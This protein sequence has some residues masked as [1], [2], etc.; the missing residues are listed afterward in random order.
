MRL[1]PQSLPKLVDEFVKERL[2]TFRSVRAVYLHGSA[3][4]G[5]ALT[6]W[7]SG[8]IDLVFIHENTPAVTGELI[9]MDDNFHFDIQHTSQE[10][11]KNPRALRTHSWLGPAIYGFKILHDPRHLLDFTQAS[12]RDRFHSPGYV[13]ARA[14]HFLN[15][16][17]AHAEETA[18]SRSLQMSGFLAGIADALNGFISLHGPPSGARRLFRD[19]YSHAQL[20]GHPE[21]YAL[22]VS[23]LGAGSINRAELASWL[24]QWET[25]FCAPAQPHRGDA[26]IHPLRFRYFQHALQDMLNSERP[27]DGLWLLLNTWNKSIAA[28]DDH[29]PHT[30]WEKV[31]NQLDFAQ[32]FKGLPGL[33]D[34]IED[35]VTSWGKQNGVEMEDLG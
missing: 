14:K 22:A 11:Y 26:D 21:I 4:K 34:V 32:R 8:D 15:S 16:A 28:I 29:Q 9:P 33:I 30:E 1:T 3:V 35:T 7:N 23:L 6:N 18:D 24:S 2:K 20:A 10:I 31:V 13:L 12:V 19:L 25:A 17:R 5:Q 27:T